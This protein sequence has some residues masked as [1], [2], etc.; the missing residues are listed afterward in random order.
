MS[1]HTG[2]PI[3]GLDDRTAQMDEGGDE[4]QILFLFHRSFDIALFPPGT[5]FNGG[6]IDPYTVDELFDIALGNVP[7]PDGIPWKFYVVGHG[8]DGW[9][10]AQKLAAEAP[11]A[12]VPREFYRAEGSDWFWWLGPGHDTPY[13][14]SYEN[15]F[16][17]NL[18]EGLRKVG[19]EPPSILKIATRMVQTTRFRPPLHLFSPPI[20]GHRGNYY[21][22]VA[23]GIYRASEG[24][25]HRAAW[26]S[27]DELA[28]ATAGAETADHE[29]AAWVLGEVRKAKAL[30]K[31]SLRT[32][33]E[34]V[35]VYQNGQPMFEKLLEATDRD[36]AAPHIRFNGTVTATP[37]VDAYYMVEVSGSESPPLIDASRT[38][39]NPIFV[40]VDG[41]GF[42]LH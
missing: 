7:D 31:R 24:S 6:Q 2:T 27:V 33:A 9:G 41:N 1:R 10:E 8:G 35:V 42:S 26:P 15:L 11:S 22:W 4:Q 30:A 18:L 12:A 40:D 39:T 23:A 28:D 20:T 17:T 21:A 29:V 34:R 3:L 14:A 13:E 37:T 32:S 5:E 38:L 19:I 36:P 25:I 16:R